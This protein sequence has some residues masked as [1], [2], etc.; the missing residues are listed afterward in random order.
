M[1]AGFQ[2]ENQAEGPAILQLT[3]TS[4]VMLSVQD[5]Q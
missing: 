3:A 4:P 1:R 2:R 5:V